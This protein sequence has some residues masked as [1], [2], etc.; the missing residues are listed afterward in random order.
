[1]IYSLQYLYKGDNLMQNNR[2]YDMVQIAIF[3]GLLAICSWITVPMTIPFTMQTFAFFLMM[4]VLGGKKGLA[5]L[6]VYDLIG[7]IGLPVFSG[8][9]G[10]IGVFFGNTG[11]FLIGFI[12]SGLLFWAIDYL[13]KEK[14]TA[15]V[16]SAVLSM[17]IYFFVGTV[18]FAMLT[19][20]KITSES[21]FS[22]FTVCTL[23]FILPDILKLLLAIT[24]SK[25]LKSH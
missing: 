7:A 12:L 8:F 2:T 13:T 9:R 10:G 16:V 14:P 15:R 5:A 17:A 3:A 24:I 1:M 23:P 25:R 6:G 4:L 19:T 21:L 20:G 22:A 18:W 11:G